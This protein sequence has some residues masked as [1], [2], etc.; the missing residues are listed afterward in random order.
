MVKNH[1]RW[2]FIG[3]SSDTKPTPSTSEK[4]VD[5]STFYESNTSKLYVWCK[6]QWYEKT[7]SGGG[8]GTSNFNQLTN[9]PKYNSTE[10]TGDT[11]IPAVPT[12]S[13]STG[14]ST[15][16]V[17]S[18][19]AVTSTINTR[20]DNLTLLK[21][22]QTAYDNLQTYDANTLYIITGA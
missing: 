11:N 21:I 10:M 20:L 14:Q 13:Q 17:M 16:E 15:T 12:V 4:V 18:Q 22:T 8:G 9:R 7:V 6:T 19:N 2:D 5:G 1:Y 3:L